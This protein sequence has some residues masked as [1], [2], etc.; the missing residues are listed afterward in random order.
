MRYEE[1]VFRPPSEAFSLIVQATIGCSW[2]RC[3]F[4][5]MYKMKKFRVRDS[6][7][8]KEDFK[9]AKKIYGNVSRIF[10]AD[11]NALAADTD[12]L[13]D[14]AKYANSLFDLER[15]SCY[16]TPQ[17]LLEKSKS[18]LLKLRKAGIK[19]L[20]VGV[21]S[22]DDTI[23]E[24]IRKGVTSDEIAEAC[25]K[26]HECGF[27][28]SV[29]VMTGIGGKE[30]SYEN[31]R[32]TAK[33]LNRINPEYTG[34]L[35][36]MPVPNTPLYVKIKRGEFILP[37]AVENLF[38]LRWM[39]ER[40]EARTIFRCNHASNYLPLKGNLPD[41]KNELLKAIDYAISHPDVL[42]PEWMRGL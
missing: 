19:L 5:G 31:A 27:D 38:E 40:I 24:K 16:A 12:F 42:K 1:P 41:D 35:T 18:E 32:N 13:L 39:V 37:N 2:N 21:E 25:Q 10:L 4:C 14:I 33:L 17:D 28:L 7:E 34:V 9:M 29:T 20:Y 30:R 15:I 36:Y 23:L 6:D 3:T 11:G 26:G 8:V 22:G